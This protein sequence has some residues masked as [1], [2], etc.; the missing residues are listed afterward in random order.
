MG[1]AVH[2]SVPARNVQQFVQWAG[3]Q[4]QAVGYGTVG[5]GSA[6]HILCEAFR[7]TARV[8]LLHVPFQ[9]GAQLTQALLAS[10]V[11]A[12]FTHV[13]SLDQHL[14]SGALR[15]I[16]VTA[17]ERLPNFPDV[18]TFKEQGIA[19]ENGSW[20][21]IVAPTGVPAGVVA[22]LHD[23][24]EAT[25]ADPGPAEQNRKLSTLVSRMSQTDFHRSILAEYERW[26]RYIKAANISVT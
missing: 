11:P 24:I 18:P 10:Q 21:G 26:G 4:K 17:T 25:L 22:T 3:D 13:V 6:G 8:N 2:A 19:L 7:D 15:M 16:G 14:R 23:A 9:G 5:I 20:G 12:T 1:L